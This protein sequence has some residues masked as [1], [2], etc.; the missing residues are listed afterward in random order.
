MS[1][2]PPTASFDLTAY[3]L[4]LAA[5]VFF[6]ALNGFFV[7]AEF[8]LVKVRASRLDAFADEGRGG[9]RAA[10]QILRNLARYLSACQLG[11]TLASLILGWLAEPAIAELLL[12]L[13]DAAGGEVARDNPY[14]HGAA[15]VIA[16]TVITGLH[17]IF[18]EQAPKIWAIHRAEAT[19]MVVAHPLR[20]FAT[21]FRPL[22]W[23]INEL[24]NL[25][26]RAA[27]LSPEAFD[28][29]SHDVAELKN[30]VVAA[31][32]AG[33]ISRRQS[34]LAQNVFG[35]MDLETRHIFVPRLDVQ[36]L[37]LQKSVDENIA[38]VREAGHSRFPLCETDLD[39]VVGIVHTR[40]LIRIF[41]ERAGAVPDLRKLSR[42]VIFVPETQPLSR[43]I[44][45][46]QTTRNHV[47]V[48]V[49]EHG[50]AVGLAFLE[51]ALE[52]IVGPL[53]DEFDEDEVKVQKA[54]DGSVRL[55]GGLALP[56]A[57]EVLG[58][59]DVEPDTGAE[60]IAGLVTA[61]LG[62]LPQ[63]G[64]SVSVGSY[65]AT[66]EKV[67]RRRIVWLRFTP[68]GEPKNDRGERDA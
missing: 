19:A 36:C 17:M 13:L 52:E 25:L 46:M 35:I 6:V 4:P 7:A 20:W 15:L 59:G 66:V 1:P 56:K 51:D 9:A 57:I 28:E 48:V 30:I 12:A 41:S 65:Q 22:I 43:L 61:R 55:A 68:E 21:A 24:S 18:G 40:D 58:L 50:S 67:S 47:A 49:D 44:V 10:R 37:S 11:I 45:T 62:R 26:L 27:G 14:V 34:Q 64:D 53:R 16:L 2:D 32:Q 54:E 23:V 31:A 29:G 63:K 8:A 60:T 39:S 42:P 38:V 5:T 33:N 3:A